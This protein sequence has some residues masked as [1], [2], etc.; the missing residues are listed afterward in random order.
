M[1]NIQDQSF[2]LNDDYFGGK[3]PS[4]TFGNIVS[5]VFYLLTIIVIGYYLWTWWQNTGRL[6]RSIAVAHYEPVVV[7]NTGTKEGFIDETGDTLSL[8]KPAATQAKIQCPDSEYRLS[9]VSLANGVWDAEEDGHILFEE[10]TRRWT[11]TRLGKNTYSPGVNQALAELQT[12]YQQLISETTGRMITDLDKASLTGY[13]PIFT[14][15]DK[16]VS[17]DSQIAQLKGMMFAQTE[18]LGRLKDSLEVS[19]LEILKNQ[20][21][22]TESA[23]RRQNSPIVEQSDMTKEELGRQIIRNRQ[24]REF[25]EQRLVDGELSAA[26]A[27]M[28]VYDYIQSTPQILTELINICTRLISAYKSLIPLIDE[29]I[30][31]RAQYKKENQEILDL[32]EIILPDSSQSQNPVEQVTGQY[33]GRG[34]IPDGVLGSG[35]RSPTTDRWPQRYYLNAQSSRNFKISNDLDVLRTKIKD[36]QGFSNEEYQ[37]KYNWIDRVGKDVM[38][39]QDDPEIKYSLPAG[40]ARTIP[41]I[42]S[43]F[44]HNNANCQR[45]YGECSTRADVP[46][47]PLPNWDTADYYDYLDQLP[48]SKQAAEGA[49][50]KVSTVESRADSN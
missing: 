41:D 32:V 8:E 24:M 42:I 34:Q 5:A 15:L 9:S 40:M 37:A 35:N 21:T 49:T 38:P 47:F 20:Q 13:L 16:L 44:D 11:D 19:S 22:S 39:V 29:V 27:N 36:P 33:G 17:A 2:Q 4:I 31:K 7:A 18:Q 10:P 14:D 26:T 46:G 6:K 12:K 43:D 50:P 28:D 3:Q 48:N 23:D 1:N 45:I 25:L 30:S